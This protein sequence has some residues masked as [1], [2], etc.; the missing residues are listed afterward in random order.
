MFGENNERRDQVLEAL[1]S[2][3]ST[4]KPN[5]VPVEKLMERTGMLAA[6]FGVSRSTVIGANVY[7]SIYGVITGLTRE[8]LKAM[9][10]GVYDLLEALPET[11]D[12]KDT[13]AQQNATYHLKKAAQIELQGMQGSG[14]KIMVMVPEPKNKM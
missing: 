10:D 6:T 13:Y 1:M 2:V 11:Q 9:I 12:A 3:I 7:S 4:N 8:Q 5:D 14:N